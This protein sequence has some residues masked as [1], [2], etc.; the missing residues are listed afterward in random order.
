LGFEKNRGGGRVHWVKGA[1]EQRHRRRKTRC[2]QKTLSWVVV[3]ECGWKAVFCGLVKI[4]GLCYRT[5]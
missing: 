4:G 2:S 5:H 3:K 1:L